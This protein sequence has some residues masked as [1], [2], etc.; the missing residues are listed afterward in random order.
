MKKPNQRMKFKKNMEDVS[1]DDKKETLTGTGVTEGIVMKDWEPISVV[2]IS[3][4]NKK[5]G[6]EKQYTLYEIQAK[7]KD[8]KWLIYKR[9]SE[10]HDFHTKIKKINKS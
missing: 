9:Y 3:H 2:I 8:G 1:I 4:E 10:I 6:K 7:S 5:E